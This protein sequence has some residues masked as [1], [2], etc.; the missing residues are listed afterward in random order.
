MHWHVNAVYPADMAT[1]RV[2]LFWTFDEASYRTFRLE[3]IR[4]GNRHYNYS[5]ILEECQDVECLIEEMA[6]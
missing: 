2:H 4:R 5:W 1:L 3:E 6:R